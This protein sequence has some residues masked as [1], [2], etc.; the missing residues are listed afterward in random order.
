LQRNSEKRKNEQNDYETKMRLFY[1]F[2]AGFLSVFWL[3]K[4]AVFLA[5]KPDGKNDLQNLQTDW[6]N[7]GK[8]MR[9]S[10]EQFK[11]NISDQSS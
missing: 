6:M 5:E 10:Y 3:A 4:P 8:D 11:I 7:I 9:K 1:H 2:T